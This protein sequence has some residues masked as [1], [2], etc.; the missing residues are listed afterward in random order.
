MLPATRPLARTAALAA[1]RV[2]SRSTPSA[3][4]RALHNKADPAIPGDATGFLPGDKITGETQIGSYPNM[5]MY[6]QQWRDATASAGYWDRQDRR[7]FGETVPEE[8][9]VL[10]IWSPDVWD[11]PAALGVK[12]LLTAAAFFLGI[13]YLLVETQPEAHFTPRT[14]PHDGLL[15]ALGVDASDEVMVEKRGARA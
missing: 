2:A 1:T 13:G 11:F 3:A 8:D 14:Y 4:I 15:E 9:E 5:P 7:N 10:N 12:R 6:N